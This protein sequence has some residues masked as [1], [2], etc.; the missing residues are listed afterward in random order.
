VL[1]AVRASGCAL[2]ILMITARDGLTDRV[3]GLDSGADDYLVKPFELAELK[4][5]PAQPAAPPGGSSELRDRTTGPGVGPGD[6]HGAPEL[7][8]CNRSR[9][10]NL[11][12]CAP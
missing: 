5:A 9:H 4:G 11:P 2:P 12:C 10:G 6:P 7:A 1:K 3:N 8:V